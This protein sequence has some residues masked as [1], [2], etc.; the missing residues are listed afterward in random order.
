VIIAIDDID[1]CE[2]SLIKDILISTKNFI[3]KENCFFIVPCDDRTVVEVF[4]DP[5]QKAGY[6]DESPKKYFNVGLR[7]PPITS[8]DLVDFANQVA[9][10]MKIPDGVVQVAVIA[11]PAVHIQK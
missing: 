4:G 10:R 2:A 5:K 8:T 7:I 11:S 3:G 9:R 1:R 6:R